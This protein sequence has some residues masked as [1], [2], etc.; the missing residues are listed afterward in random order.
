MTTN[1][2]A[3]DRILNEITNQKQALDKLAAENTE[4]RQQ[5][6]E[7]RNGR[8]IFIDFQGTRFALRSESTEAAPIEASVA[9]NQGEDL[10]SSQSDALPE[11]VEAEPMLA[12][13]APLNADKEPQEQPKGKKQAKKQPMP[14]FLEE[15]MLDEFTKIATSPMTAW[16]TTERPKA[17]TKIEAIHV[18]A[19][20]E[21]EK[22]E[23]RKSLA[24]SF[25]LE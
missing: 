18:E 17:T 13:T 5:L 14:S 11:R 2:N 16:K 8:G 7:L 20:E 24:G 21:E 3:F 9:H 6:E 1:V 15:I 22:E 4:L 10:P 12:P 25:L 19:A 23:I